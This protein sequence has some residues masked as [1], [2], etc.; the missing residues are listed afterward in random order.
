M[1]GVCK[2]SYVYDEKNLTTL[3]GQILTIVIP[4]IIF[5]LCSLRGKI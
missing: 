4:L 1:F 3:Q 2:I 5:T